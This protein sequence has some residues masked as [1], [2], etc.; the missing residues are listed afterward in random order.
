MS[1]RQLRRDELTLKD[2]AVLRE[3]DSARTQHKLSRQVLKDYSLR[4][5]VEIEWDLNEDAKRDRMFIL[6]VDDHEIILDAEELIRAV[7]WV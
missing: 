5:Q 7:R 6:R 2:M 4:H 3:G 1:H